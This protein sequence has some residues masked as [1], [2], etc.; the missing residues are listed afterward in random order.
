MT[1][2]EGHSRAA[3]AQ[4]SGSRVLSRTRGCRH[5]SRRHNARM[6]CWNRKD[7]RM[8]ERGAGCLSTPPRPDMLSL[9]LSHHAGRAQI[10]SK[11]SL[12]SPAPR[13]RHWPLRSL[14]VYWWARSPHKDQSFRSRNPERG[15]LGWA[16]SIAGIKFSKV[17][18]IVT[19][20]IQYSTALPLEFVSRHA[21]QNIVSIIRR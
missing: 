12:P 21:S 16:A 19:L 18:S 8:C 3:D 15:A 6:P 17:L 4:M 13:P 11:I 20:Y 2:N 14:H 7:A 1:C 9:S 5:Q 10:R